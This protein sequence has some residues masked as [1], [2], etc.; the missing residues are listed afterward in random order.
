MSK[1]SSPTIQVVVLKKT[2]RS[3]YVFRGAEPV[4]VGPLDDAKTVLPRLSN[5]I[6]VA[7][8]DSEAYYLSVS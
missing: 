8:S 7:V 2:T 6:A 3:P 4:F 5:I 1:L